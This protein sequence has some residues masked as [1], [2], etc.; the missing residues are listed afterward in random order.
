MIYFEK[1]KILVVEEKKKEEGPRND[2]QQ[3][4]KERQ[5]YS[6]NGALKAEM[7]NSTVVCSCPSKSKERVTVVQLSFIICHNFSSVKKGL[8]FKMKKTISKVVLLFISCHEFLTEKL[9][10]KEVAIKTRHRVVPVYQF[11]CHEFLAAQALSRLADLPQ[12]STQGG[13]PRARSGNQGQKI[14]R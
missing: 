10:I 7:S 9:G 12:G 13:G 11:T 6:A 4:N 5:R 1:E 8:H 14:V 3:T 2:K